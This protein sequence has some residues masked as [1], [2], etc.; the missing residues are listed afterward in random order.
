MVRGLLDLTKVMSDHCASR[1][2]EWRGAM[3]PMTGKVQLVKSSLV[4]P[5]G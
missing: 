1:R 3:S 5:E 2:N 4:G